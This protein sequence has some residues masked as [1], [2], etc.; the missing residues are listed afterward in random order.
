MAKKQAKEKLKK[1]FK[2]LFSEYK[3][4]AMS[5]LGEFLEEQG[6]NIVQMLKDMLKI[7]QMIRKC[8]ISAIAGLAATVVLLLGVSGVLAMYFKS[9]AAPWWQVIVALVT[10]VII[11]FYMKK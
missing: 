10:L 5:L 1:N 8:I 11:S 9:I 2:S 4:K 7:K 3:S 6:A